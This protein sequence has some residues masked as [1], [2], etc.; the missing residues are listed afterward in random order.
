MP[1]KLPPKK[2]RPK[3]PARKAAQREQ[4][5]RNL[6]KLTREQI[7]ER[8]R[9]AWETR[10][11]NTLF[12]AGDISNEIGERFDFAF[13]A[14]DPNTNILPGNF[15]PR[16]IEQ[17]ATADVRIT[18]RLASLDAESGDRSPLRRITVTIPEGTTDPDEIKGLIYA[19]LRADARERHFDVYDDSE[20]AEDDGDL[21]TS[22]P[23]SATLIR[24]VTLSR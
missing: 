10:K 24:S 5:K 15:Y 2:S 17:S 11:R 23:N 7:A 19:R 4:L 13:D 3:S 14:F 6:A 8:N 1:R 9:K 21:D 18:L 22:D 16:I 12:T 20:D